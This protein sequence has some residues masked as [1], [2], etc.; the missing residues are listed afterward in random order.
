[1]SSTELPFD[2]V[3]L[4]ECV[5]P[6]PK[7]MAYA[8]IVTGCS[9]GI[10]AA[11]AQRVLETPGHRI[12]ATA[13]NPSTLSFLPDDDARVLKL[14]LDVTSADAV[15]AAFSTALA[16]FG[17]IDVVVNNAG[18]IVSA[19]AEALFAEEHV[20]LARDVFEINFWGAARV[21]REAVR[22]FREVNGPKTGGTLIQVTS[23]GG[24]IGFPAG[25]AYQAR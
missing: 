3:W 10:G 19:D 5:R 8:R 16:A 11:L 17:R 1:M 23:V 2:A 18:A 15:P 25:S 24:F 4:G 6:R 14:A 7:R 9:T 22:V 20:G 21:S 13:R 12:V